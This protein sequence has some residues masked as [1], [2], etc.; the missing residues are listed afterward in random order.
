M[1]DAVKNNFISSDSD[2]NTG[3]AE[4]FRQLALRYVEIGAQEGV[5][6]IP[7]L[8]SEMPLFQKA[9]PQERKDAYDYLKTI[10]DIHEETLAAG[11]KAINSKQLI[12]RALSKLSL[13]PGPEIF[14]QFT[15][16][17]VVIIYQSNQTIIFWNLQL[18]RFIS[19]TVEEIFFSP[20]HEATKRDPAIQKCLYEMAVDVVTGKITGTFNP[21]IPGHEVEEVNTAERIKTWLEIPCASVLTRNGSFGGIL[22]VQRM[23][24]LDK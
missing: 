23:K 10:V 3:E 12:W 8:S 4:K 22:V 15:D 6:I 20:W 21:N 14:E 1:S 18:F 16:E 19:L 11:N 24:L 17:D 5:R 13:I 9:G 7:F 2:W